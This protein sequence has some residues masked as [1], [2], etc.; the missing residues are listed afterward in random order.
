MKI[1]FLN[2]DEQRFLKLMNDFSR[3]IAYDDLLRDKLS[4]IKD[5]DVRSINAAAN[6]LK[7][8]IA[9]KSLKV[10]SVEDLAYRNGV[11]DGINGLFN[12]I[13]EA[14]Q[15]IENEKKKRKQAR[16]PLTG[17]ST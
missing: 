5:E 13:F 3:L 16:N 10:R 15:Q 7:L 17:E 1:A 4:R 6:H 11:Y 2:K 14:G 9:R 12:I 8:D